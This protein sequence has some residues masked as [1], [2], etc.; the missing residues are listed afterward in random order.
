MNKSEGVLVSK[1]ADPRLERH[2]FIILSAYI[3]LWHQCKAAVFEV[4]ADN[5]AV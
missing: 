2:D 4:Y 5:A 1:A 3:S